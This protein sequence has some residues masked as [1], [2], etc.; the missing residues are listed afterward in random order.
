CVGETG[1]APER[2]NGLDD[3][4]DG[5]VD[6]GN[7][8]GGDACGSDVGECAPGT[9]RCLGGALTCEGAVGPAMEICNG[10]DDDCDGVVDDGIPVGAPCG[11]DVGEC[12]P[13]RNVCRGGAL[14]CEGAVGPIGEICNALDDDCDGAV[15]EGLAEG[16]P[17]GIDEGICVQGPLRCIAGREG[18]QGAVPAGRETCDCEADDCDGAT[19]DTPGAR[20]PA[21]SAGVARPCP[22]PWV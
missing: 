11:T 18:W 21:G 4:C 14:V 20:C 16:G 12:Q 10:L 6:E 15:D 9:T 2:C 1:P 8:E 5:T 7:P 3:D 19:A 22:P 17:C 13:G